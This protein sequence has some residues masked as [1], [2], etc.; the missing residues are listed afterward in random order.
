M[1]VAEKAELAERLDFYDRIVAQ[2]FGFAAD[3]GIGGGCGFS[4][5]GAEGSS[6]QAFL[7]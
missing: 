5:L 7:G 1:T 3:N 4:C 6:L 2:G